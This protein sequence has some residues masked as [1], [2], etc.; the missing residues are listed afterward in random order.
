MNR[1]HLLLMLFSPAAAPLTGAAAAPASDAPLVPENEIF[2][3][4]LD[5]GCLM[6]FRE[7]ASAVYTM[8]AAEWACFPLSVHMRGENAW[9]RADLLGELYRLVELLESDA[10]LVDPDPNTSVELTLEP[11]TGRVVGLRY[12]LNGGDDGG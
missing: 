2:G 3:L 1:R 4:H 5:G 10:P 12:W 9:T 6:T 11:G 8:A 7:E